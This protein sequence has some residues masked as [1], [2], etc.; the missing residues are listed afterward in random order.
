M[1][2]EKYL[3]TIEPDGMGE[4]SSQQIIDAFNAGKNSLNIKFP[5]N[6]KFYIEAAKLEEDSEI[7][8]GTLK[9]SQDD[10]NYKKIPESR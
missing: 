8:A 1:D 3:Q 7:L 5:V 4:Y 6:K 10:L 9:N 2:G